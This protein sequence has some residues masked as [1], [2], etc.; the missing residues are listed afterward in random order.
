MSI[1]EVPDSRMENLLGLLIGQETARDP[2]HPQ[3]RVEEYLK[4]II[5]HGAGSSRDVEFG[6]P[7]QTVPSDSLN[8]GGL[9][10]ER[11]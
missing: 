2:G 9:F 4:Y 6:E 11:R 1:P 5:E 3:S 10:L 7:G 8:V